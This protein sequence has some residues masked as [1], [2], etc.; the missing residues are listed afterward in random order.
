MTTVSNPLK[1]VIDKLGKPYRDLEFL[2]EAFR[3]VL[4]ENGEGKIARQIPLIQEVTHAPA[5]PQ[6]SS[7]HVQLYSILFQLIHT[8]EVNGA[9]QARRK[10]EDESLASVRGL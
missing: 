7:Q 9:V 3:E 2:L 5:N 8:V 10:Q 6:F 4:L 1:L